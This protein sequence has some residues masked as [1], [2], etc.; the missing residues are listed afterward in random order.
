MRKPDL[1]VADRPSFKKRIG[2][3]LGMSFIFTQQRIWVAKTI[4]IRTAFALDDF[5]RGNINAE[6]GGIENRSTFSVDLLVSAED[7]KMNTEESITTVAIVV[8]GK[9]TSQVRNEEL[10]V[11]TLSELIRKGKERE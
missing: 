8:K 1:S 2:C 10:F 4:R 5:S 3:L 7:G 11:N 6:S 9:G